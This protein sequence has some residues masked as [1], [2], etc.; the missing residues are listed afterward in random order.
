[1]SASAQ[2]TLDETVRQILQCI[3]LMLPSG[4]EEEA[5]R[6]IALHILSRLQLGVQ[7]DPTQ[8][9]G[10][11]A[12]SPSP[13]SDVS[14]ENTPE[15]DGPADY[16]PGTSAN[17]SQESANSSL[18]RPSRPLLIDG[19]LSMR[20]PRARSEEGGSVPSSPKRIKRTAAQRQRGITWAQPVASP[21]L[22]APFIRRV[23]PNNNS[24]EPIP[25]RNAEG[26][27]L[28]YRCPRC[29]QTKP[30]KAKKVIVEHIS[31]HGAPGS[32]GCL[33]CDYTTNSKMV[34][35]WHL[36]MHAKADAEQASAGALRAQPLT[37]PN[38]GILRNASAPA[39]K[40][41]GN[42][43]E[44]SPAENMESSPD[45]EDSADSASDSELL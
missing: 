7:L 36:K 31:C 22:R 19:I 42:S 32:F 6:S 41:P 18:K 3:D 1:M 8:L 13:S 40:S 28:T 39:Q 35:V 24:R 37:V 5:L 20:R 29:P 30:A 2:R 45:V 15:N 10:P 9:R 17:S 23:A 27:L 16:Q 14:N 33:Q 11:A 38:R 43:L 21:L 34:H 4:R 26:K 12:N 44:G 25:V